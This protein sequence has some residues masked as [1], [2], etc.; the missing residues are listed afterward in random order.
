M[1]YERRCENYTYY[2]SNSVEL[3][4]NEHSHMWGLYLQIRINRSVNNFNKGTSAKRQKKGDVYL[5][6]VTSTLIGQKFNKG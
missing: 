4:S 2:V 1:P 3:Q 6:Y 5:G